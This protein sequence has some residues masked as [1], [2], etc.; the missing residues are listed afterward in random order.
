MMIKIFTNIAEHPEDEKFRRLNKGGKAFQ[1]CN[2]KGAMAVFKEAGFVDGGDDVLLLPPTADMD[3]VTLV[4]AHVLDI[5]SYR[6]EEK[7]KNAIKE[8]AEKRKKKAEDEQK[9]HERFQADRKEAG[10]KIITASHAQTKPFAGT[11]SD[12]SAIGVDLNK[13]GGG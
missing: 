8:E 10:S 5:T 1:A 12:F 13:G 2:I 3:K 6:E 4:L 7:K 9:F 11:K